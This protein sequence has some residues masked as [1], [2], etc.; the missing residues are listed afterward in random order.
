MSAVGSH[1][2]RVQ[3]ALRLIVYS[4]LAHSLCTVGSYTHRVQSACRLIVYSRLV[5]SSCTV[6]SQTHRV[7]SA[8]TL[9]VYSQL[10]HLSHL[11]KKILHSICGLVSQSSVF[12]IALH[13]TAGDGKLLPSMSLHPSLR[14][15]SSPVTAVLASD[16]MLSQSLL[17]VQ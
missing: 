11:G 17:C 3:S 16:G 14:F 4:R 12:L 10:T 8:R 5:H 13:F 7:K 15:V 6:S 2:H 9:I 1:N